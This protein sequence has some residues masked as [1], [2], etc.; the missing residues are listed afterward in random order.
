M[1]ETCTL[2]IRSGQLRD[3]TKKLDLLDSRHINSFFHLYSNNLIQNPCSSS[4]K[5]FFDL[6]FLLLFR[7]FH[8]KRKHIDR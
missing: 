7:C 4:D 5:I 8:S 1:N 3:N 6:L 2:E